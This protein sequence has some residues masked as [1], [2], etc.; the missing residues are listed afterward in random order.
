[1]PT[2]K[3][4][5]ND[6][7]YKE[8]FQNKSVNIYR[9]F[10]VPL[11]QNVHIDKNSREYFL[12]IIQA[13]MKSN[14]DDMYPTLCKLHISDTLNDTKKEYIENPYGKKD[15]IVHA[16]KMSDGSYIDII[17]CT[18]SSINVLMKNN[19]VAHG[20]SNL[21]HIYK[22]II[23]SKSFI[24]LDDERR[25]IMYCWYNEYKLMDKYE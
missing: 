9:S 7:E 22:S 14:V 8:L 1:M 15:E 20:L 17:Q 2:L 4:Y 24:P 13:E 19:L 12:Y 25:F 16:C 18:E 10:G 11:Y 5:L 23:K 21:M 6:I 3:I